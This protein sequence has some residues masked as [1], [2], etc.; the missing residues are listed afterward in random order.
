M[1]SL[2]VFSRVYRLKDA[3]SHVGIFD[4]SSLLSVVH[5]PPSPFPCV[6]KYRG[7]FSYSLYQVVGRGGDLRQIN[8][9]RKIPLLVYF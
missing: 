5:L 2:P 6:N 7:M 3:V 4:P 1:S 8:S 9:C